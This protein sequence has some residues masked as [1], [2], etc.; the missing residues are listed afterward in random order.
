[1]AANGWFCEHVV[2]SLQKLYP[3][4]A[5]FG[6]VTGQHLGIGKNSIFYPPDPESEGSIAILALRGNVPIHC[7]VSRGVESLTPPFTVLPSAHPSSTSANPASTSLATSLLLPR[8]VDVSELVDEKGV[9]HSPRNAIN[10]FAL[11]LR[12]RRIATSSVVI[13]TGTSPSGP[14]ILKEIDMEHLIHHNSDRLTFQLDD[15]E[16]PPTHVAFFALTAAACEEDIARAMRDAKQRFVSRGEEVIGCVMFSCSERGPLPSQRFFAKEALDANSYCEVFPKA[17][18]IGSYCGGE[19]G[20]RAMA[21]ISA[22]TI[23]RTGNATVC[24]FV[25]YYIL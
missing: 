15:G 16:E 1:M 19:I 11:Q 14:F 25:F 12:T 3:Q 22:E 10:T 9:R 21:G 18:L 4:A 24:A 2:S 7:V 6:G 20:P 8:T 17:P 5:I 13:G 23:F